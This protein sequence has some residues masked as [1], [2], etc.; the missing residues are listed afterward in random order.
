MILNI[1]NYVNYNFKEL[2]K[3]GHLAVGVLGA[4]GPALLV[5]Y[6][7]LTANTPFN[8]KHVSNF[9]CMLGMLAA[10]LHPL[11][12]VNRDYSSKTISLI[13]NSKQNRKNY[14]LAN[15]VI[16]LLVSLLYVALG[17]GL[18]LVTQQLGVPGELKVTFLLGFFVNVFLLVLTYFLLGYI[19][20]LYG[21]RSGAVYGILTAML[22]FFP[23]ILANILESTHNKFL[24][25][26]IENFPGYFYPVMV[27]SNP[28]SLLQYF[29]G[30][31]ILIVLFVL[32]LKK[33]K[34][35]EI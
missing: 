35:I 14:V 1:K 4:F 22:L 13:N 6:F 24:S 23:N 21:V 25:G 12:F 8:I 31:F 7:I 11:Y 5:S 2:I 18:L 26:L 29:I 15:V 9:Y 10:V 33:S 17:I 27:G 20:L 28:L 16:A 34:K 30:C 3:K 32:V 19:L